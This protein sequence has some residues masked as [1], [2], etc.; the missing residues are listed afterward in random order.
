MYDKV[1]LMGSQSVWH[2]PIKIRLI[3]FFKNEN[4]S[5]KKS[6]TPCYVPVIVPEGS[7]SSARDG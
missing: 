5:Y 2:S 4:A 6:Y 7:H 1:Y 3:Y